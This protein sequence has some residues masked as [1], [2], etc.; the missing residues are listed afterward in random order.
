MSPNPLFLSV[1][2][3]TTTLIVQVVGDGNRILVTVTGSNP[4][5]SLAVDILSR[6]QLANDVAGGGHLQ[7]LLVEGLS[8]FVEELLKQVGTD[9]VVSE[10]L[11]RQETWG[12]FFCCATSLGF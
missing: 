9:A 3:G 2:F 5:Q 1:D 10:P 4:Q 8:E 11:P 12:C 6:M 7:K